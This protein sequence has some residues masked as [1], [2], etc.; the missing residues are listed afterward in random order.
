MST[1]VRVMNAR[2]DRDRG[3]PRADPGA[4]ATD[5]P[6]LPPAIAAAWGVRHRPGKGP[7]PA[8]SVRRIVDA[9]IGAAVHDGLAAVSMKRVAGD[10]G[11]AA[12][13]L[14][15]YVSGKDELL[16]LMID[17]AYGPPPSDVPAPG[18]DWRTG[19]ARWAWKTREIVQ[20][21]R[22]TLSIPISGPPVTPNQVR[23]MDRGLRTMSDTA[24]DEGEKMAVLLLVS[25]FVRSDALLST[26]LGEAMRRAESS[27]IMAGYSTL[28][29]QVTDAEE[30]PA[31]TRVLDA[32][33]FDQPD[34][35][36]D[37][38][39]RFGLERI[40]DGVDVLVRDR[41]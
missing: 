25:G 14:Y 17:E 13:S 31:L 10:L 29:R 39:F 21:H 26:Q 12:M 35:H 24:L 4:D 7:K 9:A 18:D 3:Q 19:L 20:Q 23:W 28:L 40:L 37:D 33:V 41:S 1:E 5:E 36:P 22:W 16:L 27:Q 11:T 34:E 6:V 15:R 2:D 32:G 38:D 8:L 30:F